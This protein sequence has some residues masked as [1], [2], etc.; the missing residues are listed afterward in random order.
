MIY[1]DNSAT[2]RVDREV[3]QRAVEL[4]TEKFGNPSSLHY[5]GAEAYTELGVARNQIA[6]MLGAHT[7]RI[8]F[9][10]GGTESNNIAI[11]GGM[12]ANRQNGDHLVT[13][14]IEHDSILACGKR[15]ERQGYR[16][17]YVHPNRKTHRIQ[18][19]D[20]VD[21]VGADT[22]MVSVMQANNETGEILPIREIVACVR[23][24]NPKTLIHCDCVQGFGKIPFKLHVCD[25]D[26]ISASSHKIHGPKGVGMLYLRRPEL[27]E[28][29]ELGGAQEGK[30]NPGTENVPLAC[31]FGLAAD[32]ALC[33]IQENAARIARVRAYLLD[34]LKAA[35]PDALINSPLDGSP[36]ILNFS[37]PGVESHELVSFLSLHGIYVSSGSA[38]TKGARS[39]VL[40]AMGFDEARVGGALRISF[41]K[42]S[43]EEEVDGL[44]NT[45]QVYG[46]GVR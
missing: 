9:T 7:D 34:R 3:A 46:T 20:I 2:T 39:H 42:H 36:Y 10:S 27:V 19:Q 44:I 1:F 5:L 43:T 37:L 38:C 24:K 4:M 15:L 45:L 33:E 12:R 6:K 26:M 17:T 21:A 41:S 14:A 31:A 11:Q 13:T 8:Y 22:A 28:P 32:Q 16:V 30:I 35:R 23:A 25:V 40:R 18:V 29:L